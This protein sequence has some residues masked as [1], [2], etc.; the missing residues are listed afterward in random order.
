MQL[1]PLDKAAPGM[2]LGRSVIDPRGVVLIR[3]GQILSQAMLTKLRLLG[4]A[5]VY[6]ADNSDDIPLREHISQETRAEVIRAV[7]QIVAHAAARTVLKTDTVWKAVKRMVDEILREPDVVVGLADLKSLLDHTF[8]HS[9]NVAVLCLIAAKALGLPQSDLYE[10]GAGALLHDLGKS[11]I[12]TEI[13]EKSSTLTQAEA[14]VIREHPARGFESIRRSSLGLWVAH[15]AFQ[16]HERWDGSGYPRGLKGKEPIEF[17]R[18]CA[19][20]DVFDALTSDRPYRAASA[21]NDTLAYLGSGAG[22]LLDPEMVRVI[23]SI[24]APFPVAGWVELN[25]GDYAVVKKINPGDL[26]RPI[27][28]IAKDANRKFYGDPQDIDLRARPD[29][30]IVRAV[31]WYEIQQDPDEPKRK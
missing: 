28:R 21:H 3:A 26:R 6:I 30:E 17:A 4:F 20:C 14:A 7:D 10:L 9:V 1:F 18:L 25:T 5:S 19:V 2:R 27:I 15:I 16:H 31:S 24:A 11:F 22:T 13:L 8:A 23:Q 29:L 12:P